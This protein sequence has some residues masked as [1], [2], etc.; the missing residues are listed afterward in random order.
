MKKD[1]Y[2]FGCSGIAKSIID[3]IS[4]LESLSFSRIYFV[5]S[6]KE[7]CGKPFYGDYPVLYVDELNPSVTEGHLA[8]AA[9]FKPRDIYRRSIEFEQV[10]NKYHLSRLT[11]IDPSASVSPSAKVGLGVYVA[12]N[13]VLDA[14]SKVCDDSIILFNSVISREVTV[15]N[16]VFVSASVV[17]KGSVSIGSSTFIS[18]GC[19]VTKDIEGKAFINAGVMVNDVVTT[20]TI[21]GNKSSIMTVSLPEDTASAERRL[22]FFHP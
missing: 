14:D 18:A 12:P 17:V 22:R 3:S 5:D 2:I 20:N 13:T 21:V 8:I 6:N 19:L 4:R 9:Y 1:L 10:L 11:I 16:N 7:K 15:G